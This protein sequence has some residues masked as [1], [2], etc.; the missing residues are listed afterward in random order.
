MK[1]KDCHNINDLRKA[2]EKRLPA[3][4]FHYIDGAAGDEWT[5]KHNT[6]SFEQYEV[7]P[8]YLV[9]VDKIDTSTKV[10]GTQIDWPYICSP[11]GYHRLFHHEGEVAA[12]NA[13]SDMGTIF[14]LSTLSTTTIEEVA[15]KSKGPKVFQ[16]YV[17]K[18]RSISVEYIERC[19]AADYD[20][21]CLTIDVPC[22]LYTS[23]AADD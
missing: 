2:A 6:N 10:L 1:L 3:A 18:D 19:K 22:L 8:N 12:A 4:M 17:L 7:I 20:A 11:T 21:L 9:D 23:D 16:I 14:C 15:E 13:A 5:I